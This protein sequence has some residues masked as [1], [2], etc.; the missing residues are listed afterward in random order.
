MSSIHAAGHHSFLN[1]LLGRTGEH[2]TVYRTTSTTV[3]SNRPASRFELGRA[4]RNTAI[5]GA[6]GGAVAGVSMLGRIGLPLLGKVTSLSGI[7]RLTGAGAAV[8]LATVALPALA[9][10]LDRSPMLKAAVTGAGV[11]AGAG[12]LLPLVSPVF[13]AIAG[14]TIGVGLHWMRQHDVGGLRHGRSGWVPVGN[15]YTGAAYAGACGMPGMSGMPG[16]PVYGT[17]T[18][19]PYGG[20]GAL[21]SYSGLGYPYGPSMSGNLGR[22]IT[23]PYIP[24][25]LQQQMVASPGAQPRVAYLPA[26]APSASRV[27]K[28]SKGGNKAA[29]RTGKKTSTPESKTR[30]RPAAVPQQLQMAGHHPG[31]MPGASVAPGSMVAPNS[32]LTG[33]L[34]GVMPFAGGTPFSAGQAFAAT[35]PQMLAMAGSPTGTPVAGV[36][37]L[38]GLPMSAGPGIAPG[39]VPDPGISLPSI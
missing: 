1:R 6:V 13:G 32:Y 19:S 24:A 23:T 5:G 38:T 12:M 7:V 36:P 37:V 18:Y 10:S 25:G 8:G 30:P 16:M 11:G 26:V 34:A 17:L 4:L 21:G 14:A 9:P 3:V 20:F 27:E 29:G 22:N 35:A 39:V 28:S 2:E 15:V 33:G 31:I